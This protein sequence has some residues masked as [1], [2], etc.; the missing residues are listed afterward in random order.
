MQYPGAQ[1][2]AV[3]GLTD[4]FLAANRIAERSG[5]LQGRNPVSLRVSHWH[6]TETS[7]AVECCYTSNG[8]AP[9]QLACFILPPSL[10]NRPGAA[11][12][13]ALR[14]WMVAQHDGGA[15][16]CSVCAGAFPLAQAGLLNGRGAT[17]HWALHDDFAALFPEVRLETEKLI[18]EDGDVI[19]AGGVM[20]WVDLGLRI[21]DRFLGPSVMLEVAR[22]F[23]V[24]PGGREQRFYSTFAPRLQHGDEAVLKAQHWLHKSYQDAV[25]L[26]AMA[27]AAGLSER[28][29]LRR[30]QKATGLNPTAYLQRLRVGKARELLELSSLPFG[31]IAWEV[32]YEDPA[33]FRKVF[34]KVMG[35]TPGD[36]RRRFAVR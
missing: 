9:A 10:G 34:H 24:D 32:G 1:R 17:T 22:F 15:V 5:L 25:S 36:Y 3:H 18:V 28:T 31:R 23:L 27:A 7:D 35:L 2:A 16:A 6:L 19:T 13:P 14:T 12:L 33:A 20:A 30:F 21:V 26:A 8:A 11:A 29:F 4:L